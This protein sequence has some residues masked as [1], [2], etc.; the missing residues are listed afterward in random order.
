LLDDSLISGDGHCFNNLLETLSPTCS[1]LTFSG[2]FKYKENAPP[3]VDD[4]RDFVG[5]VGEG[6]QVASSLSS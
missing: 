4:D 3:V 6:G 2:G 1:G 5:V